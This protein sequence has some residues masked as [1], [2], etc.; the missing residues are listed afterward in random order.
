METLVFKPIFQD[1]LRKT[2]FPP[3]TTS[4]KLYVVSHGWPCWLAPALAL[5]LP[6][7]RVFFLRAF[8]DLFLSLG[9]NTGISIWED[10]GGFWE[11]NMFPPDVTVFATG[12]IKFL[13]EVRSKLL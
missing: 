10:V 2:V 5:W 12:P 9:W 7:V 4:V 3:C 13:V 6:L 11:V 1:C 8:H